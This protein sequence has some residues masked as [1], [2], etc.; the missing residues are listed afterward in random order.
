MQGCKI[1]TMMNHNEKTCCNNSI[2][3]QTLKA[4]TK[5]EEAED[6][7]ILFQQKWNTASNKTKQNR[8]IVI[9]N[10]HVHI[11]QQT[12]LQLDESDD[13]E[14]STVLQEYLQE[15][16]LEVSLHGWIL[17]HLQEF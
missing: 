9:S 4:N 8:K 6:A 12:S 1:E 11:H 5:S 10:L 2:G 7:K 16:N 14:P 13:L 15:P 3:S 17:F